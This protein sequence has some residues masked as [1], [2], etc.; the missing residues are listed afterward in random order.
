[1][2]PLLVAVLAVCF[3][4]SSFCFASRHF[5][6]LPPGRAPPLLRPV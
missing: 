1:V 4:T 5:Y 2:V 6:I 3:R